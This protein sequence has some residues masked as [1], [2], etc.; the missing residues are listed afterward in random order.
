M[1]IGPPVVPMPVAVVPVDDMDSPVFILALSFFGELGLFDWLIIF[2][3]SKIIGVR[4]LVDL[5]EFGIFLKVVEG[6]G[7]SDGD[8]GKL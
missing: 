7:S 3:F 6:D 2:D 1:A 4:N 5:N 8:S